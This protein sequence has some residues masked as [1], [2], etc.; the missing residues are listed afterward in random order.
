MDDMSLQIA[1]FHKGKM[2]SLTDVRLFAS[3]GAQVNG[4]VAREGGDVGAIATRVAPSLLFAGG[5]GGEHP[6]H[7]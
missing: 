2:T 3:V 4:K 6:I 7:L 1:L 5:R